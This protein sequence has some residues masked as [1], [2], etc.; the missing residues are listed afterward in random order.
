M[1]CTTRGG[2]AVDPRK[3]TQCHEQQVFD[4]V[5]SQNSTVAV[6][7]GIRGSTWRHYG[8]CVETK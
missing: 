1:W 4:G 7:V 5:C 3:T 2:L 8:V 6:P